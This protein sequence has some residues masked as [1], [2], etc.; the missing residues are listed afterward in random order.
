M[1]FDGMI[2]VGKNLDADGGPASVDEW[3][4]QVNAWPLDENHID[5]IIAGSEEINIDLLVSQNGADDNDANETTGIHAVEFMLW[6]SDLNV[7]KAGSGERPA[8]DLL[9]GD[10]TSMTD[11]W[12]PA[13]K[14]N[15]R[16]VSV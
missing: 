15:H 4:G 7:T 3:E 8:T 10:L 9:V 16:H 14:N 1:R 13:A 2:T 12:S 5:T 6:D 11:E